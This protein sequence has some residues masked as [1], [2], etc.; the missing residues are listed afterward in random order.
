MKRFGTETGL[1][2]C[3]GDPKGAAY[4]QAGKRN[5]CSTGEASGPEGAVNRL[6]TEPAALLL[7]L[8]LLI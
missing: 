7:P 8:S 3:Q 2:S 1:S 4:A 6:E 5:W